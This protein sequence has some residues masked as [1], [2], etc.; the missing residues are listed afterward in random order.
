MAL[1][2]FSSAVRVLSRCFPS[3]TH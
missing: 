3:C 2:P 1:V